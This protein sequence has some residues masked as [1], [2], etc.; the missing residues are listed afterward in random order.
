MLQLKFRSLFLKQQGS[1]HFSVRSW[2]YYKKQQ[3]NS[4]CA[5]IPPNYKVGYTLISTWKD[6]AAAALLSKTIFHDEKPVKLSILR[7]ITWTNITK[8]E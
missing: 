2:A 5:Y 4:L 1:C 8:L 6:N 7:C 3:L